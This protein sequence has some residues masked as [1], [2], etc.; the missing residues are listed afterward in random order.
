MA[1]FTPFFTECMYQ[2][3]RRVLPDGAEESVHYCSFP[4]PQEPADPRIER[5]V[6]RM[7][8]VVD[9]A[10]TIR[11]RHNRP[12]KTP[13][14]EM[15]IVHSD[16]EFL[17]DITGQLREYVL[18]EMNVR[19]IIPCSD[20]LKYANL[21][22]QP[23]YSI[24]GERLGR[25][26]GEVAK[27]V[28]SMSLAEILEYEKTAVFDAAGHR[29]GVGDIKI[30][31]DFKLP[32]DVAAGEIDA[33]SDGDA[34]VVLDLRSDGS[35]ADAGTA[36]E[37][38]NRIQKLR[39]KAGLEPSD[40]V[41]VFY[42]IL[43]ASEDSDPTALK[44]VVVTQEEYIADALGSPFMPFT[45]SPTDE[46][47]ITDQLF[48]G[49]AGGSFKIILTRPSPAFDE[50]AML[51]AC[52]GNAEHAINLQ[53]WILSRD[54][55]MLRACLSSNKGKVHVNIDGQPTYDV[56]VDREFFLSMGDK[57]RASKI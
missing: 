44:R 41:E 17:E 14:K 47:I 35:L 31:R 22:A 11:E 7:Q 9:L 49:V 33:A 36:R 39:K 34:L 38:V 29:L 5:S 24:L 21:R 19:S 57:Y 56:K 8:T 52:G 16:E 55:T 10:R 50:K 20:L 43:D 27:R 40:V 42:E 51:K 4:E 30:I 48:K 37:I 15:I 46:V 53:T 18:E 1:P 32:P 13:L 2:N 45:V 3:L 26:M 28:K 6:R 12:L 54:L 23:E 25:S